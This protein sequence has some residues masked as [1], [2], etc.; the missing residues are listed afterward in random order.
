M[1]TRVRL[2]LL[3][4]AVVA[5]A[6]SVNLVLLGYVGGGGDQV[7][8]LTPIAPGLGVPAA[9]TTVIV[10]APAAPSQRHGGEDD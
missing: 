8:K 7:G 9:T 2:A 1:G 10:P 5:A 6:V 4:V 3:A